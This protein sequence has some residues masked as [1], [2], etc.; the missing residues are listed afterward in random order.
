MAE[1]QFD[2]LRSRKR[3]GIPPSR[4]G[5]PSVLAVPRAVNP[6]AAA[7]RNPPTTAESVVAAA[8]A[9]SAPTIPTGRPEPL[10]KTTV[11][12]AEAEDEFLNLVSYT[13]KQARPRVDA[14]RSA[15]VRL[16]ISQLAESKTPPEIV[17]EL[18]RRSPAGP[19]RPRQG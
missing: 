11:H 2:E 3:T 9:S 13:G 10:V 17:A 15:I 6:P 1:S 7:T 12:L 5:A 16:A 8:P 19:G 18:R 14:S 4:V